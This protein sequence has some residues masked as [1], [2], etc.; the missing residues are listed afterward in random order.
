MVTGI[1]GPSS[2]ASSLVSKW[3]RYRR[4][5]EAR[6]HLDRAAR[7]PSAANVL[8]D[9]NCG[10]REKQEGRRGGNVRLVFSGV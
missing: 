6:G 10:E 7:R 3:P 1:L 2:A 5:N 9:T 8:S 4:P